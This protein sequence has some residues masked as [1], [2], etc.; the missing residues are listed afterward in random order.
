MMAAATPELRLDYS[1]MECGE[2]RWED[3]QLLEAALGFGILMFCLPFDRWRKRISLVH[4]ASTID[5]VL[6]QKLPNVLLFLWSQGYGREQ[7]P[8]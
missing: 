1:A 5:P 2:T 6:R 7:P 4:Q 8:S 3:S